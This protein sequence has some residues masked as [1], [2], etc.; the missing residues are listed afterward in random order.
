[1]IGGQR[2]HKQKGGS[3][4]HSGVTMWGKAE[5]HKKV[6]KTQLLNIFS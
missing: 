3:C 1:M 4:D 2:T 5:E 6:Q